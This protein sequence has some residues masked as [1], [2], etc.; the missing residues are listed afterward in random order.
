MGTHQESYWGRTIAEAKSDIVVLNHAQPY[1]NKTLTPFEALTGL[2]SPANG[3]PM[4]DQKYTELVS[5][6]WTTKK[7]NMKERPLPTYPGNRGTS[8]Q[9]NDKQTQDEKE[10]L[11][12]KNT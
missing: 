3:I 2:V 8:S 5:R 7:K 1:N 9:D 12:R 6:D 10:T 11:D 4:T